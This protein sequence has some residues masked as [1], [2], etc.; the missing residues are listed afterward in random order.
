MSLGESEVFADGNMTPVVRQ[1]NSVMRAL[2][3]GWRGSH[4]VLRHLETKKFP[5]SPRL[6]RHDDTHEWLTFLLGHSLP[7]DLAG[8]RQSD[9]LVQVGTMIRSY[10]D[11]IADFVAPDDIVWGPTIGANEPVEVICHNDIAPWNIVVDANDNLTG[12]I[13]WD[14]LNPGPR[15]HDLAYAAWRFGLLEPGEEL[16]SVADCATRIVTLLD[17][18]GLLLHDRIGFVDLII[19]RAQT[20]F[21]VVETLGKQGVPGYAALYEKGAHH[22]GVP[23]M[24]WISHHR[25]DLIAG[26]ESA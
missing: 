1:G 19:E 4:A 17:A 2:P 5:Y 9:L 14:L 11:A 7:A 23:S 26:I 18:Y 20:G 8:S 22:W 25:N 15:S 12:L 10:H 16:G 3:T 6:I 13:D 21:D 24:K